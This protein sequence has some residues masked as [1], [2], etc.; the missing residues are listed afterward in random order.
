MI[1]ESCKKQETHY[2]VDVIDAFKESLKHLSW[3]DK[4]SATAAA[5]KADAILVKVGYPLSPDTESALSIARYYSLVLVD[6]EM[7]LES[8]VSSW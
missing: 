3:M 5:E 4:E 6:K 8:I 2:E 1:P 7:F